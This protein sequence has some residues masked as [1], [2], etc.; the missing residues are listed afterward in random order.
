MR[1]NTVVTHVGHKAGVEA[2]EASHAIG[3]GG[4]EVVIPTF[5]GNK[6]A[7][8]LERVFVTANEFLELFGAR[9]FDVQQARVA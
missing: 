7:E 4:S 3:N 6:A 8:I 9:E 2:Y 5:L 1:A